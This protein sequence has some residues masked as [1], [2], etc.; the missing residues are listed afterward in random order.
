MWKTEDQVQSSRCKE[1]SLENN[2]TISFRI[3]SLI[4]CYPQPLYP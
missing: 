4:K 2:V 3:L 1:Y